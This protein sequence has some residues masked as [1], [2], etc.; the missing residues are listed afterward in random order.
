MSYRVEIDKDLC[1]SSG[2]CIEDFPLAF[3]FDEDELAE[4]TAGTGHL[5]ND[6]LVAAARG[7][8]SGALKVLT[9][10]GDEVDPW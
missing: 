1:I 6:D 9:E 2:K 8:P 10:D 3:R 4:P 7:C 5:P